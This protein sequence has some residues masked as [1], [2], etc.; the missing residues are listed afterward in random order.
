[1]LTK[2][3]R[4]TLQ[5]DVSRRY[6]SSDE[7]KKFLFDI[8]RSS[9]WKSTFLVDSRWSVSPHAIGREKE[10]NEIH[11][12]LKED[13]TVFIRS[14]GGIGKSELAKMYAEKYKDESKTIQFISF[15][16]NLE[17]TISNN[18]LFSNFHE[19]EYIEK[20]KTSD[21]SLFNGIL[22]LYQ[23]LDEKTLIVIDNFNVSFDK[24]IDR[25]ITTQN[26]GYKVIFTTRNF[27]EDFEDKYFELGS[28]N[29]DVCLELY[30][31]HYGNMKKHREDNGHTIKRML[32]VVSYNTL[33]VKLMALNCK[34][35]RIKPEIMLDK[36]EKC[37]ISTIQGK[38]NHS[39][40]ISKDE[41]NNKLMYEHLCTIFD[42]SGLKKN[43]KF[44]MMNLSL[45]SRI[46]IDA[47]R[48]GNWCLLEDFSDINSLVEGGWVEL[49]VE[50][51]MLSLHHVISDLVYEELK[52][53]AE[54]CDVFISSLTDVAN[55]KN[56]NSYH[57][58]RHYLSFCRA[59]AKRINGISKLQ[60]T[61]LLK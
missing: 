17:N 27:N 21:E 18:L 20:G 46:K 11:R 49:D 39:S 8:L 6:G 2:L 47:S 48:F 13:N 7:L 4:N 16:T 19:N 60:L 5:I 22:K 44:I 24:D 15:D 14:M 35:Q 10:L 45:I 53:D 28:M 36:L 57:E 29:E 41:D 54:K 1:M 56:Y 25:I 52:P 12:R 31:K 9:K 37:E 61:F 55:P 59:V 34:K 51:D 40:D 42:M 33:L 23:E 38:I 26:N 30:Y 50:N 43:E 3:F 58:R 32:K